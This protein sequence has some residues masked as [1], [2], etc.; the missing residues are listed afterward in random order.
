MPA[1]T[2]HVIF[3]GTFVFHLTD[4]NVEVLIPKI[5]GHVYRIG[6]WLG[7][8]DLLGG[9]DWVGGLEYQLKGVP[10]GKGPMPLA[11]N[12][13]C[14]HKEL[15]P[16]AELQPLL[17]AKLILPYP[18]KAMTPRR[19]KMDPGKLTGHQLLS[20]QGNVGTL[21]I[22]TYQFGDDAAIHLGYDGIVG[23]VW[24]P[25][26]SGDPKVINLHV[27]AAHEHAP[28]P[29]GAMACQ[30]T[31]LTR[32]FDLFKD[33]GPAIEES[34]VPK[35]SIFGAEPLPDGVLREEMEDLE[36]RLRRLAQAGRMKK[37][38]RDL[39]Q[40]W[41]EN[42]ALDTEPDACGIVFDDARSGGDN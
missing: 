3:H 11:D 16:P 12:L 30:K 2:L 15:K 17:V 14:D 5:G 23:P 22:F 31:A 32:C 39:N 35:L 36:P 24:E 38:N 1:D 25:A 18:F 26:A 29:G 19:A 13:V 4:E 34:R 21:Q 33:P 10:P 27:F 28:R 7:E 8:T 37:D 9:Q 40:M 20:Y 41:F 6:N 42:E